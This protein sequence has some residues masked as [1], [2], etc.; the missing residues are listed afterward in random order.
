M[1]LYEAAVYPESIRLI[2]RGILLRFYK[3]VMFSA[4][5]SY[6]S[7][8]RVFI[9][10][11]M[12]TIYI[13]KSGNVSI[14]S[15]N[16]G[17]A[18]LPLCVLVDVACNQPFPEGKGHQ[19]LRDD[20]ISPCSVHPLHRHTDAGLLKIPYGRMYFNSVISLGRENAV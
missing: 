11:A 4:S 8:P 15:Q 10:V 6:L 7:R 2:E 20:V 3:H 16:V 18:C 12:V 17:E 13:D 5:R 19:A 14:F 9:R 1:V